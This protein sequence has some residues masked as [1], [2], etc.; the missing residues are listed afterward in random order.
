MRYQNPQLL[1]AL[2]AIAIPIII[3]LF[4][5]RKHKTVYFSSIRFLKEIKEENKK[6]STLKNIL[7]LISRILAISFLVLAFARPYIPLNNNHKS[8]NIFLYLDNSFSME[9]DD[10]EGRLLDIAKEK[11]RIITKSYSIE[12][13]FYIITNDNDPIHKNSFNGNDIITEIDNKC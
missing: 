10:G 11:A 4:S 8:N 1:Y 9:S 5:F 13:N 6:R 7:I 12:S 3:H 2:L